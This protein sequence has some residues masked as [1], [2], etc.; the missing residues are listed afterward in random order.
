MGTHW[1]TKH[2]KSAP[3]EDPSP[4]ACP[5]N[6]ASQQQEDDTNMATDPIVPFATSLAGKQIFSKQRKTA[7][8]QQPYLRFIARTMLGV[9]TASWD[10]TVLKGCER[11]V[12]TGIC[13]PQAKVSPDTDSRGAESLSPSHWVQAT[14]THTHTP[15][16]LLAWWGSGSRSQWTPRVKA[17]RFITSTR[18]RNLQINVI[19]SSVPSHTEV[20]PPVQPISYWFLVTKG[21]TS[22]RLSSWLKALIRVPAQTVFLHFLSADGLGR[23]ACMD[24]DG[25]RSLPEPHLVSIHSGRAVSVVSPGMSRWRIQW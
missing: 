8:G 12:Q 3:W 20:F 17:C 24:S 9:G 7:S 23:N 21:T 18:L 11:S 16:L 4:A 15:P 2:R 10:L 1:Y 13:C 19:F 14:G 25:Y 5:A 6:P 22:W